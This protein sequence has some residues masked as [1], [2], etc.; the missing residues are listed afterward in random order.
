MSENYITLNIQG[1]D[2][3]VITSKND[4]DFICLTDIANKFGSQ[5]YIK[6][7]L[8]NTSTIEFLVT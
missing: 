7:W 1:S 5:E 8:Q 4:N 3:R 6:R 2:V